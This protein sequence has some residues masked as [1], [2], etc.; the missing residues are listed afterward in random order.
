METTVKLMEEMV[1][2]SSLFS[3]LG[4]GGCGWNEQDIIEEHSDHELYDI[5]NS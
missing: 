4:W 3:L 2:P 1:S 5:C